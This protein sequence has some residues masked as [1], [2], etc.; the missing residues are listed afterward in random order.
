MLPPGP[1][2]AR[3][4]TN[5]IC[6]ARGAREEDL[7]CVW[8]IHVHDDG[9]RV[10]LCW[11]VGYR[12]EA[13]NSI[14]IHNSSF[15]R[16]QPLLIDKYYGESWWLYSRIGD[17]RYKGA[18]QGAHSFSFRWAMYIGNTESAKQDV[19]LTGDD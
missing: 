16:G 17:G 11:C 18:L 2:P 9:E 19:D 10:V 14:P 13:N 8:R 7:I 4:D 6:G 1:R 12:L 5:R 15:N 3:S